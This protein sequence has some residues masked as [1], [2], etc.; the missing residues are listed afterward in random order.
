VAKHQSMG[1]REDGPERFSPPLKPFDEKSP[2]QLYF[3]RQILKSAPAKNETE[4]WRYQNHSRPLPPNK[5]IHHP[6]TSN[7]RNALY[8]EGQPLAVG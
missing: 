3:M 1:E 7:V 2:Q 4:R 8:T 5:K 6:Y